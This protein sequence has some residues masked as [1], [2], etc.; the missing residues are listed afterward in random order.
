MLC[1]LDY[2]ARRSSKIDA[3]NMSIQSE[4][5]EPC[6]RTWPRAQVEAVRTII[7][8]GVFLA[9]CAGNFGTD[10]ESSFPGFID[11]VVTV[12]NYADLDGK[13]SRTDHFNPSSNF[14]RGVDIG[15]PG[16][17]IMSTWI[18]EKDKSVFRFDTGCSMATPFVTGAAVVY[19]QV[20][21]G[22]PSAIRER[23][24]GDARTS[25]PGRGKR[26]AERLL[27]LA[28]ATGGGSG[29]GCGNGVCSADETDATCADDCGCA[30]ALDCNGVSPFGCYCDPN[31]A[32]Q[33]DCCADAAAACPAE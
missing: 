21:G 8:R 16:T 19:K 7:R 33:G 10:V 17:L 31:C 2:V 3:V 22:K 13:I 12:S 11:E 9:G 28:A 6:V 18:N 30:A 5:G 1:G 29:E 20:F 14:G 15:G 32:A 24:I 23:L 4:C 26:H 27:H 25:Y